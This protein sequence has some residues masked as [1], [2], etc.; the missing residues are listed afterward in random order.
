LNNETEDTRFRLGIN[1]IKKF[2]HC[3]N[4]EWG[5]KENTL[6]KVLRGLEI[7]EEL[8]DDVEKKNIKKKEFNGELPESFEL[9]YPLKKD[10][11]FRK[12]YNYLKIRRVADWQIK[13]YK[14]GFCLAGKYSY[15][16]IFPVYINKELKCFMGRDFTGK[17][18]LRY[19]NSEGKKT[20]YGMKKDHLGK[21]A[22]CIEGAFDKLAAERVM[23]HL[24]ECKVDVIGI[25][26]RVLQDYDIDLLKKYKR[27]I[28]VPDMD[29]PGILGAMKDARKLIN[30]GIETDISFLDTSYNDTSEAFCKGDVKVIEDL[31]KKSKPFGYGLEIKM[32]TMV[33]TD[34][35]GVRS[36]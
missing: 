11:D 7:N 16:I 35:R 21:I 5:S 23:K 22:L 4:C 26:G 18:D 12:A 13:K 24:K 14:I 6:D 2:A 33:A 17:Q 36:I 31:V 25:P 30:A 19:L 28:R 3:F 20:I 10:I 9:L 34:Y 32:R 8:Q 27:I 29:R 15:R 1:I